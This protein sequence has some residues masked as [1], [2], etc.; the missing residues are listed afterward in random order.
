[1]LDLG[2]VSLYY[3]QLYALASEAY[4]K[5]EVPVSAIVVHDNQV[6]ATAYNEKEAS[7][8]AMAHAEI[9]AIKRATQILGDWRLE[10][11]TLFCSLEPCPMCAGVMIQSRLKTLVYATKD[12]KWGTHT[13]KCNLFEPNLFNHNVAC[14]YVEDERFGLLLTRFLNHY[15]DVLKGGIED[16]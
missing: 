16:V 1:M 3:D 10:Q 14:H 8:D 5:R 11:C 2:D 12:W 13:T 6:I 9:L 7:G 15:G 4:E